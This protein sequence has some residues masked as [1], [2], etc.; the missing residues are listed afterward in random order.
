MNPR[1]LDADDQRNTGFGPA[2]PEP[3]EHRPGFLDD[4]AK[5]RDVRGEEH[6]P[7]KSKESEVP[8]ESLAARLRQTG[9]GA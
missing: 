9:K 4:A 7:R 1:R 8:R 3:V 5:Q 2:S 6:F